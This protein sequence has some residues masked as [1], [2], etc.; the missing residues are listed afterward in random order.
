MNRRSLRL[1]LVIS[2]VA[3]IAGAL[4]LAAVGLALLFDRHV[5]RVAVADLDARVMALLPMVE[6]NAPDAIAASRSP[7]DPQYDRPFS[8]RYWMIRLGE[9]L[10]TSRSLW[11][12]D[13][14]LPAKAPAPGATH[15]LTLQ[16]P[17]DQRLLAVDRSFII[18]RNDRPEVLRITVATDSARLRD[19]RQ[20]FLGDLV[21][22]LGVLAGLLVA[23][24]WFQIMVGLKPL[25]QI[26]AR[27]TALTMGE[28]RRLGQNLPTEVIPLANQIDHLLDARDQELERARHRAADLAHG[29]KTPLQALLGDAESLHRRGEDEIAD[30]IE[31]V[32]TTMRRHVDRELAR[33]RIQADRGGSRAEPTAI[34]EKLV[35]LLARTP[36]GSEIDWDLQPAPGVLARIDPDDLTEALG[37]LLENAL[38]H[39]AARIEM[40]AL[41]EGDRAVIR[42][43]DDG[44]GIS[45]DQIQRIIRRGERLDQSIGGQGIGLAIVSDIVEAVG[46]ELS[47][48]NADPGLL[49]EIRLAR[50]PRTAP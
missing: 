49:A 27:V 41:A 17:M 10:Q 23:A 50:A 33:A 36:K 15:V 26:R 14:A 22:F 6:A 39:C 1:R 5:E 18:S 19:A 35:K 8:G 48:R 28:D 38:R 47:L 24:S 43:R 12:F 37:A 42:I 21:P 2:G 3:A 16:G 20:G 40:R 13:L 45:P 9:T 25:A 30:S 32:V 4:A 44:P 31:T 34:M 29:F 7:I 46:G 11:D